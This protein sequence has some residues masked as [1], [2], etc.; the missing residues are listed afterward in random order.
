MTLALQVPDRRNVVLIFIGL[1]ANLPGKFASPRIACE[2]AL[3]RL[4]GMGISVLGRSRWYRSEPVPRSEQPWFINGIASVHT[5]LA[6][7]GLLE[8][9]HGIE[10]TFGRERRFRNEARVLDLDLIAYHDVVRDGPLRL[11]HPR[12]HERAFVLYPLRELAPEW[13]HPES[14][15]SVDEMILCLDGNQNIEPCGN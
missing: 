12:L 6:P 14:G 5:D 2:S 7:D 13:R 4:E 15:R 10:R 9:L 11:P 8:R 3:E 1:G